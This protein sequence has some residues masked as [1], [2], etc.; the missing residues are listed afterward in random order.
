[1][2]VFG[3]GGLKL[4]EYQAHT[5]LENKS[6]HG[7]RRCRWNNAILLLVL[8]IDAFCLCSNIRWWLLSEWVWSIGGMELTG[9]R[10]SI[11]RN[12]HS[13]TVP[14]RN[15]IRMTRLEP[16]FRGSSP[17]NYCLDHCMAVGTIEMVGQRLGKRRLV[18]SGSGYVQLTAY[19][20]T[21]I[22]CSCQKSRGVGW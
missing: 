10:H 19:C 1:M 2:L 9:E 12:G 18:S 15:S 8:F 16:G 6:L 17:A 21:V 14:A 11:G 7:R 3:R 20:R 13:A 5:Y 22:T 4:E